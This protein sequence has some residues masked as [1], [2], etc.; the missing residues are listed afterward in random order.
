MVASQKF[1]KTDLTID[2]NQP[3][4]LT[5]NNTEDGVRHNFALYKTKADADADKDEIASTKICSG[6]CKES[7]ELDLAPGSYF[8][9]CDLHPQQMTG[10][11]NAR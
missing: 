11:L 4:M 7:V 8:F 10:A 6:P 3:V 2:A 5:V 9:H 1:D